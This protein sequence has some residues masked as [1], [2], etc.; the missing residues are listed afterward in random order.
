MEDSTPLSLN[1]IK[2]VS[3]I[4]DNPK[5]LWKNEDYSISSAIGY[6]KVK[7]GERYGVIPIFEIDKIDDKSIIDKEPTK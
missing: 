7:I 5:A 2:N 6:W 3:Y 4:E 1:H